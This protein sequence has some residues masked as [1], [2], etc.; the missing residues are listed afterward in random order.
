MRLTPA[1]LVAVASF[2]DMLDTQPVGP[3]A[4]LRV[5]QHLVLAARRPQAARR[6]ERRARRRPRRPGARL[7]VPRRRATSRRWSRSTASSSARSTTAR[8]RSWR[9]DPRRRRP[10]PGQAADQR[11]SADPHANTRV[12]PAGPTSPRSSPRSPPDAPTSVAPAEQPPS[13]RPWATRTPR[14]HEHAAAP[15]L[16]RH[17]RAR[18]RTRST[19]TSRRGGYGDRLRK[20]LHHAARGAGRGAQGLRPARP[21]RRR[22]LHGHEGV[23]HAQGHDGQVPRLQRG[24]VRARAPSRTASSCR[25][26][27]TC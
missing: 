16:R 1:Y 18:P 27:R 15:D 13:A 17:R 6:A 10:A 8:S 3:Q 2:Y 11:P 5:H 9:A 14:T 26:S 4:R 19:C 12:G 20:A 21:R 25:R 24:R 22:L 7:R 23:V